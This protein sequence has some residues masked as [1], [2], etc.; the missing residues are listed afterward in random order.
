MSLE[1]VFY[2]SAVGDLDHPPKS[3]FFVT[4]ANPI[5]MPDLGANACMVLQHNAGDDYTVYNAQL[6]FSFGSDKIAI[7]R[8]YDTTSIGEW[9]DWR[10]FNFSS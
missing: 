8:K 4:V 9:T 6:A 10:Y 2:P 3:H 7:R 1:T 5:G